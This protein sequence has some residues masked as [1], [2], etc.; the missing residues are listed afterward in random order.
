MKIKKVTVKASRAIATQSFLELN[1]YKV[2]SHCVISG[3]RII[4]RFI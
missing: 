4:L 2:L 3:R 1:G